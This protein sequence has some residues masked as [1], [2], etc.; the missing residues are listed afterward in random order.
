MT[1]HCCIHS[2]HNELIETETWFYFI[3]TR[4]GAELTIYLC[5]DCIK[6]YPVMSN[7]FIAT[8][9]EYFGGNNDLKK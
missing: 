1:H 5:R 2:L 3:D 7:I 9:F 4:T 6:S 8:M